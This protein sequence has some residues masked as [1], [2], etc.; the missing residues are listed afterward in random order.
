MVLF[1][2]PKQPVHVYVNGK[3]AKFI[4]WL[5]LILAGTDKTLNA[6]T[7]LYVVPA[8]KNTVKKI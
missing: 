1:Y 7:R 8:S 4:G 6:I 2:N 3:K 5:E